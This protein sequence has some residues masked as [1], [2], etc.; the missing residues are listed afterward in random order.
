ML[1]ETVCTAWDEY[2]MARS[3]PVKVCDSLRFNC[4]RQLGLLVGQK[5]LVLFE[6]KGLLVLVQS[7]VMETA[8]VKDLNMKIALVFF[9]AGCR[10][11]N[12]LLLTSF[13]WE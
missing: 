10:I 5:Q 2:F 8:R 6:G 11:I 4:L 3:R 7:Q 12:G 13:Q 9:C 1:E